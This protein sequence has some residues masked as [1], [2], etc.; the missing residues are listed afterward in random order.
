MTTPGQ[1]GYEDSTLNSVITIT[2]EYIQKLHN[3]NGQVL[4]ISEQLPAVNNSTSGMKLAGLLSDW[5]GGFKGIVG[6]L[7]ALNGKANG[8]LITNR[9]VE[10][11]TGAAAK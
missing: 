9:N 4:G 7:T 6:A 8:I 3:V 2:D 11:D 10:A 1:Y 5:T